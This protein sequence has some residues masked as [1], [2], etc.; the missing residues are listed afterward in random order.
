MLCHFVFVDKGVKADHAHLETSGPL[1]HFFP[2]IS[3]SDDTQYFAGQFVS[4]E[5]IP[6]PS[7]SGAYI[8]VRQND[9]SHH[10]Q[11]HGK[12]HFRHGRGVPF[13]GVPNDDSFFSRVLK[14]YFVQTDPRP[15]DNLESFRPIQNRFGNPGVRPD[16][17][18]VV[19][20]N[21]IDQLLE[22]RKIVSVEQLIDE[23]NPTTGDF[24]QG[25]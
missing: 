5:L 1:G 11:H 24:S 18:T 13:G 20:I 9:F 19:P 17:Q 12:Y 16:H 8:L 25:G 14:I 23:T 10:G 15:C 3:E 22:A 2:H 21:D 7:G 6:V 4:R